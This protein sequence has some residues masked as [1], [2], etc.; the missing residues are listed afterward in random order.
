MRSI[1]APRSAFTVFV[2]NRMNQPIFFHAMAF[3]KI[4][5]LITPSYSI[6]LIK[7]INLVK[8]QKF[9]A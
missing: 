6:F 2:T 9:N 7:N 5:L 4:G 3:V 8:L 1:F